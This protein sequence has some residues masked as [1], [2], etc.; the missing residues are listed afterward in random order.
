MLIKPQ[1]TPETKGMNE[2]DAE[3]AEPSL[4]KMLGALTPDKLNYLAKVAAEALAKQEDQSPPQPWTDAE[5]KQMAKMSGRDVQF[6]KLTAHWVGTMDEYVE[7][8]SK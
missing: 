5:I 1:T 8:F 6:V 7:T 4:D 2:D 3:R